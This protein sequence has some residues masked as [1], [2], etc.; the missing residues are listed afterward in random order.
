MTD[1]TK[2]ILKCKLMGEVE[3]TEENSNLWGHHQHIE[4]CL[5]NAHHP[6]EVPSH[7]AARAG[8]LPTHKADDAV[9]GSTTAEFQL[10]LFATQLCPRAGSARVALFESPRLE[11][12]G[13]ICS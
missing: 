1:M 11:K 12:L 13:V 6:T 10:L 9:F 2:T 5:I 3:K 8:A 4:A 7:P